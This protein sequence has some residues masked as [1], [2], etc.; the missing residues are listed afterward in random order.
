[1]KAIK[2]NYKEKKENDHCSSVIIYE[3][4]PNAGTLHT[5]SL[6]NE[7]F[8]SSAKRIFSKVQAWV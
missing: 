7:D 8:Q 3:I 4:S 5:C 1:M 6:L 2:L